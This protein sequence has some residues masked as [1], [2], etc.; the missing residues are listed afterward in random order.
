MNHFSCIATLVAFCVTPQNKYKSDCLVMKSSAEPAVPESSGNPLFSEAVL[1]PDL[2]IVNRWET[3]KFPAP[4]DFS[5]LSLLPPMVTALPVNWDS[6]SK[7]PVPWWLP[8][9]HEP[10]GNE[11]PLEWPP[12]RKEYRERYAVIADSRVAV[13][14]RDGVAWRRHDVPPLS[15][16][17]VKFIRGRAVTV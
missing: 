15:S 17:Q 14:R 7:E 6:I 2:L 12:R 11:M 13:E 9:L 10:R 1:N 4:A 3:V 16:A 8:E 5:P